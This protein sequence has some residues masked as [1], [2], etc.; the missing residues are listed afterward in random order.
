MLAALDEKKEA[1]DDPPAKTDDEKAAADDPAPP[2][3]DDEKKDDEEARASAS[4]IARVGVLEREVA[5]MK[6]LRESGERSALLASRADL[7][8]GQI[9]LLAAQPLDQ[10]RRTLAAFPAVASPTALT[11]VRGKAPTQGSLQ[12]SANDLRMAT[13]LSPHAEMLDRQM[14]LSKPEQAI[15][16]E[17]DKLVCRTGTSPPEDDGSARRRAGSGEVRWES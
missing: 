17:G 5:S 1:G 15:T 6:A 2:K 12:T 9:K 11:G 14:G 8:E 7:T 10:M 4:A 13:N 16:K 3:K